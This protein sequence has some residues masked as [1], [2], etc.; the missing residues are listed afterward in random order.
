[1]DGDTEPYLPPQG[2]DPIQ[3]A[4]FD[5]LFVRLMAM[6]Y[7]EPDCPGDGNLDKLVDWMDVTNWEGFEDVGSSVYDLNHDGVTDAADLLIILQNFGRHCR[8]IRP[9]G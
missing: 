9:P 3:R 2:L 5:A 1:M 7:S 6:L 8:I 4:N